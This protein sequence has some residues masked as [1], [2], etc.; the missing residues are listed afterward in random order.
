MVLVQIIDTIIAT[1]DVEQLYNLISVI[2]DYFG[3]T[4]NARVVVRFPAA[5][6]NKIDM[7]NP[8][9]KN[10]VSTFMVANMSDLKYDND[11]L[12]QYDHE[13]YVLVTDK[14]AILVYANQIMIIMTTEAFWAKDWDEEEA[15]NRIL[16]ASAVGMIM[17]KVNKV[18]VGFGRIFMMRNNNNNEEETL[19]YLSDVA[20]NI[21]HQNKGL[22]RVIVNYLVSVYIGQNASQRP[23]NGSICL[24]CGNKGSGAISAP[25]LYRSLGFEHL[26]NIGNRIAILTSD[27]YYFRRSLQR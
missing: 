16:S 24:I 21:Q 23:T 5:F 19:G 10:N 1:D 27:K 13:Q 22:G 12:V 7:N 26:D 3:K 20:V 2:H 18:P 15:Y 4:Y 8:K 25:K 9:L 14:Q 6:D 17:D 11:D